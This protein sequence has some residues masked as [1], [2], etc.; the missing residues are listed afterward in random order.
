M[1]DWL[2][3]TRTDVWQIQQE[4]NGT[5]KAAPTELIALQ[6]DISSLR[7][8]AQNNKAIFP[9]VRL[10]NVMKLHYFRYYFFIQDEQENLFEILYDLIEEK[11]T[12]NLNLESGVHIKC[13]CSSLGYFF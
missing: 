4:N 6:Q 5:H 10:S 2:L 8:L 12:C 13:I 1:C 11:R 9:R 3:Q 7:K